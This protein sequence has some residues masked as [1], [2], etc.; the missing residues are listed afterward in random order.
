MSIFD[1]FRRGQQ[2]PYEKVVDWVVAKTAEATSKVCGNLKADLVLNDVQLDIRFW[3]LYSEIAS[4][5]LCNCMGAILTEQSIPPERKQFIRLKALLAD[6]MDDLASSCASSEKE[7]FISRFILHLNRKEVWDL[8]EQYFM[9]DMAG[10]G[11][12][13][14]DIDYYAENLNSNIRNLKPQNM[15]IG[16]FLIRANRQL[17]IDKLASSQQQKTADGNVN[18]IAL[19][20]TMELEGATQSLVRVSLRGN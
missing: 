3:N 19:D 6:A 9:A 2:I 5:C 11:I 20:C 14:E 16:Y 12:A 1:A 10:L 7:Q 4:F 8:V 13:A 17:A 18:R 15:G